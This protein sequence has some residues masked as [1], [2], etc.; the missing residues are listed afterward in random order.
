M[1]IQTDVTQGTGEPSGNAGPAV[2]VGP[3]GSPSHEGGFSDE[4]HDRQP[5]ER[6][7]KGTQSGHR[8][9]GLFVAGTQGLGFV[10]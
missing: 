8:A 1:E 9:A 6:S 5:E 3:G 10:P 7:L 4:N 2:S